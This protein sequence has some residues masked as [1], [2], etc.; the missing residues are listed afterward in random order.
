MDTDFHPDR[1]YKVH[2]S[3]E[4]GSVCHRGK[5]PAGYYGA[6]TS[7]C[8]SPH[9]LVKATFAWIEEHLKDNID[10]VIWTGDS[11]RHDKDD[12]Y[13]RSEKD[14]IRSNYKIAD[15]FVTT[16][17]D[18]SGLTVPVVPTFG[19][20]DI[21]P[22]N[23]MVGGPSKWLKRYTDIWKSFVPESQ[24]HTFELGGWFYTEV[25]P[26]QLVVFS[27]NTLYFFNRNAAI[28]DC[29]HPSEPG[30]KQMEWLRIQLQFVRNRGM[31]AILMG[32]V[33]PARTSGKENWDETCWQKYTLWLQQYRDV[34]VGS[35][36]GHMNMD[37]F[38]LQDTSDI[39]LNYFNTASE[40]YLAYVNGKRNPGENQTLDTTGKA[41]KDGF[42]I[43]AGADYL[44]EL[45][46]DWS[47]LPRAAMHTSDERDLL[48]ETKRK[49]PR[50]DPLGGKWA[51]R[52]QLSL[53]SPSIVPNYFPTLRVFEYNITGLEDSLTWKDAIRDSK[54]GQDTV[55]ATEDA[56]LEVE[57]K[58]H[59][60]N[61]GKKEKKPKDPNLI[62]PEPPATT[63]P[64]GPAYSAQP[65]TLLG[66]TQYF[67][68]LT[69]L[70]NDAHDF[71]DRSGAPK[72]L[73]DLERH[74][75]ML[76]AN[77]GTDE[78][79]GQRWNE[80]VHK[81][82]KPAHKPRPRPFQFEVEY[83]TF[84]DKL[85][86]IKDLTVQNMVKLAYRIGQVSAKSKA[87]AED[88]ERGEQRLD[89]VSA[90]GIDDES[91]D[92]ENDSADETVTDFG[93][94]DEVDADST[95]NKPKKKKKKG[96]GK[97]KGKKGKKGNKKHNKVWLHFLR[98]AF[99][100]TVSE[101]ELKK[102]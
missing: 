28:D 54:P 6:E 13:D 102:V 66:Y 77:S 90:T 62:V 93:D 64:P 55:V 3:T 69:Y 88:F 99:V 76:S 92:V 94:D 79:S 43:E 53:V 97:G 23:I 1:H 56:D 38:I 83:S 61:K 47:K 70:N 71:I 96:H 19:N 11:A 72:K 24:R 31:K 22:H 36:Y 20:N 44:S 7:D 80:G 17:S 45:R 68:N 82:K 59:R 52:Y 10:F 75:R 27:L 65:L 32:H 95:G 73:D 2:S 46:D 48:A 98:H 21:L 74:E 26:N 101:K 30:F 51:E 50:K 15:K 81:G 29:V 18:A 57:K 12:A 35:L 87:L 86:K 4:A 58:K 42:H 5:G 67:A 89:S 63:A 85:Y 25:I 100:S 8:D 9:S 39:N 34:I 78:F 33:P 40:E 60:K 14:V 49:K 16:L 41:D 37:H 84:D 91:A